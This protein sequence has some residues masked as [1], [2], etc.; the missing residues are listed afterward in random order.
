MIFRNK[1]ILLYFLNPEEENSP[2]LLFF[3]DFE[4]AFDSLNHTFLFETLNHF[5][6][7]DS[8]IDWI[9]V[10]YKGAKSSVIN[11]GHVTDFFPIERVHFHLIFSFYVLNY[12]LLTLQII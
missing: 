7:G 11:N 3:S 5:N 8:L 2:A 10:F 12:Y 1:V 4:K 6:F 9:K